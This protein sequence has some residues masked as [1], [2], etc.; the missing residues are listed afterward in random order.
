MNGQQPAADDDSEVASETG[1]SSRTA[2]W[3]ELAR[4]AD[5]DEGG[6]NTL[7]GMFKKNKKSKQIELDALRWVRYEHQCACML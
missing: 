2:Y 3:Y 5:G 6:R 4:P 7:Q 1:C